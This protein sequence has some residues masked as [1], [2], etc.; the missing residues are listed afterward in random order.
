M[1]DDSF[2][3]LFGPS[4]KVEHNFRT[5]LRGVAEN[6]GDF[7]SICADVIRHTDERHGG[8]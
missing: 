1:R 4:P 8:T 5:E 7:D 2:E 6:V 3:Q